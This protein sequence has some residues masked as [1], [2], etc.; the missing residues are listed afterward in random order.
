MAGEEGADRIKTG[1]GASDVAEGGPDADVITGESSG[2]TLRGDDGPD[3]LTAKAE[4]VSMDGGADSDRLVGSKFEDRGTGGTGNDTVNG[5]GGNDELHGGDGQ[6]AING[7]DG[8]DML[9]G[10]ADADRCSGAGGKDL[11]HGGSPGGEANSPS[12]TDVCEAEKKKSCKAGSS[13]HLDGTATGSVT[14]VDGGALVGVTE[15]WTA[16]FGLDEYF[17]GGYKGDATFNVSV[18]GTD[19]EGCTYAGG[20]VVTGTAEMTIFE[21]DDPAQSYYSVTLDNKSGSFDVTVTCPEGGHVE[22]WTPLQYPDL[23]RTKD[24]P[25]YET[26]MTEFAGED[27]FATSHDQYDMQV[28]WSWNIGS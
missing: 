23:M 17:E 13:G 24:Y 15:D 14:V 28:D 18:S 25:F 8:N 26:G 22:D 10:D 21:D 2:A 19:E 5:S 12:D 4:G 1:K 3:T 16:E 9:F 20:G 6:D 11:C 7:G 27:H